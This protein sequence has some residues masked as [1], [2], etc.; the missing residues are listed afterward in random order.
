MPNLEEQHEVEEGNFRELLLK[1]V[2][3]MWNGEDFF[4]SRAILGIVQF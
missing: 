3:K 1:E 2:L 4:I